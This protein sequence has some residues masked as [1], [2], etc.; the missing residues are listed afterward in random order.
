MQELDV[1]EREFFI[2]PINKYLKNT[3]MEN[4]KNFNNQNENFV[5]FNRFVLPFNRYCN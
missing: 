3:K 2:L 4:Q 1:I 5:P